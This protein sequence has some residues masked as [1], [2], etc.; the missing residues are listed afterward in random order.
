[1]HVNAHIRCKRTD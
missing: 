1:M